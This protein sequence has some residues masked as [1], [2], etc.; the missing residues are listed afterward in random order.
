[1]TK[2]IASLSLDLDNKWCYLRTHGVAG[3]DKYPSYLDTVV[4]RVL[5]ACVARD[6]RLTC[7]VVGRD[8]SIDANADAL[9]AL[10][11]AGHEMANH[12]FDH[13][14]WLH[15]LSRARLESEIASA[16]ELIE[17][18]TGQRPIGFRGPAYSVNEDVFEIL[19]ERGYHYDASTLPTFI[20][21]LARW[22]F[23]HTASATAAQ[24]AERRE[25]FGSLREGL[26]PIKPYIRSTAAGP[27]VEIPVT[28]CPLVRLPIHMTYL[29]YLWQL[30]RRLARTYLRLALAT[31]RLMKVAPSMLLHPLD[32]LGVEDDPDMSFFPGMNVPRGQKLELLDEV[33]AQLTAGYRLVPLRE[34]AA[35]VLKRRGVSIMAKNSARFAGSLAATA[36]ATD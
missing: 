30:S 21:P 7:F 20:G 16:E 9:A 11:T 1:M 10:A 17:R 19:A 25:M 2:P 18:A 5:R 6:L 12:T 14:P 33:L 13:E 34:H 26:R 22:Y 8:A 4:P 36:S 29:V 27:I 31:C 15:T 3:W 24:E 32:F 35:D 23:R 28:T